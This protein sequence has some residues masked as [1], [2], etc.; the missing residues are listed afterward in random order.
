MAGVTKSA[1]VGAAVA[2]GLRRAG[3]ELVSPGGA[4]VLTAGVE[5]AV[6][7]AQHLSDPGEQLGVIE[8][9]AVEF[10]I[11]MALGAWIDARTDG[12]P[13]LQRAAKLASLWGLT[14]GAMYLKGDQDGNIYNGANANVFM[15][16]HAVGVVETAAFAGT[17]LMGN[18]I[19]DGMHQQLSSAGP[20][21]H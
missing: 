9:A 14:A 17:A 6:L 5:A 2:G 1:V 3:K 12:H 4:V 8:T 13:A 15:G 10:P 19:G 11:A 21:P 18:I 16:E 7:Q 20:R